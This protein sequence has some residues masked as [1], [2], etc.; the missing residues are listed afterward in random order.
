MRVRRLPLS[1]FPT[2]LLLLAFAGAALAA[3]SPDRSN[4]KD[5]APPAAYEMG[6]KLVEQGD[7][8][9]ARKAFET[10]QRKAPR[11]PDVLNMLAYSQRKT[12]QLD[13]AIATYQRALKQRPRFP[14]A[15][16]YLAEAYLQAALRELETL[17]G[18][19]EEGAKERDQVIRALEAAAAREAWASGDGPAS[20]EP[21]DPKRGW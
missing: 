13:R 20:P 11:D 18:Y 10:A 15:R 8:E 5:D 7:F 6:M 16:E 14:Q 17:E 9:K 19:G 4:A 1:L 21:R 3:G 2:P 12:G